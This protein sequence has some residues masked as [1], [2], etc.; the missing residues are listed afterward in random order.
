ML[1]YTGPADH[2]GSLISLGIA[3][4]VLSLVFFALLALT[5]NKRRLVMY[6]NFLTPYS[7]SCRDPFDETFQIGAI[8]FPIHISLARSYME[9]CNSLIW[10]FDNISEGMHQ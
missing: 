6:D 10:I 9:T 1:Y 8:K 3:V 7:Y 5:L 2:T 4:A